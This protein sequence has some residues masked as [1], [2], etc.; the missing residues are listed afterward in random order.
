MAVNRVEITCI[1][2]IERD[3]PYERITHIGGVLAN[4]ESWELTLDDAI[5]A[6]VDKKLEFFVNV[7][8][9]HVDVEIDIREGHKYLRTKPDETKKNNLLSLPSCPL[10]K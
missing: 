5:Q 10:W 9:K 3:N 8:G 7:N 6:I 1:N 4:G 2:K